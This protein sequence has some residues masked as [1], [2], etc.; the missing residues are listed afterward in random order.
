MLS[1]R[2]FPLSE[3]DEWNT[4]MLFD[5]CYEVD[6]IKRKANGEKDEYDRYQTMKEIEP[7]IDEQYE[8]DR[9]TKRDTEVS[10]KLLQ[11]MKNRWEGE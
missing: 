5:W 11:I 6:R 3:L 8:M 1:L 4:G 2:G 7:E 9:L 10:R